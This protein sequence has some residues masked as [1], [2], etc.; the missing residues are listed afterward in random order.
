MTYLASVVFTFLSNLETPGFVP[1]RVQNLQC[2]RDADKSSLTLQWEK[3]N[4]AKGDK[5]VTAYEIRFRPSN[6][7]QIYQKT[8]V[9]APM[10]SVLLTKKDGLNSLKTY[11]LEVRAKNADDEGEWNKVSK[12]TGTHTVLLLAFF[13]GKG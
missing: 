10:T 6:S 1:G 3:P 11:D 5:D 7:W 8:M 4:N 13:T 9:K 12:Y 2:T